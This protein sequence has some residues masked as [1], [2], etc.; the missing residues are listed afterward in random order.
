MGSHGQGRRHR[1]R[2][3]PAWRGPDARRAWIGGCGPELLG[4]RLYDPVAYGRPGGGPLGGSERRHLGLSPRQQHL[5]RGGLAEGQQ[6]SLS[7][8]ALRLD[9][10]LQ[11]SPGRRDRP[12][13]LGLF[14]L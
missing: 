10:A 11:F 9:S 8:G 1:R 6:T 4:Q 14:A 13:Q 3:R 5:E 7:C 12:G 2:C